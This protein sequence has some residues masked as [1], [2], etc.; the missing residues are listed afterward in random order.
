[1][2]YLV[3]MS[4]SPH[5]IRGASRL[6]TWTCVF[7]SGAIGEGID[8]SRQLVPLPRELLD[9]LSEGLALLSPVAAKIL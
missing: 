3:A 5:V 7:T 1:V 2:A 4:S 9:V 6:S 8:D